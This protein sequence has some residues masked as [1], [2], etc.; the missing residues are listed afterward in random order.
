MSY[1]EAA[2]SVAARAF[3]YPSLAWNMAR[4]RLQGNWNWFDEIAPVRPLV[5]ALQSCLQTATLIFAAAS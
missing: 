2:A 5:F 3:F 1:T 4:S